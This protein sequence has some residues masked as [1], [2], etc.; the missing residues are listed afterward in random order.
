M[1]PFARALRNAPQKETCQIPVRTQDQLVR[2]SMRRFVLQQPP[3]R[4]AA[5]IMRLTFWILLAGL[6]ACL[7]WYMVTVPGKS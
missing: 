7:L 5:H 1:L 3:S 4:S 6:T 2:V